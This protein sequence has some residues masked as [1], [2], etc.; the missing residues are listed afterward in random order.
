[1][2]AVALLPLILAIV[3][4]LIYALASNPK[5]AEIGRLMFACGLLVLAFALAK[6]V[7]HVG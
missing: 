4:L 2:I 7:V 5:T 3:G 6:T 1:M